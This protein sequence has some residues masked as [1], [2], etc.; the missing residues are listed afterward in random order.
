MPAPPI[1]VHPRLRPRPRRRG[2]HRSSPPPAR[3]STCAR[4]RPWP[5]TARSST[6]RATR[7]GCARW[8]ASA[9]CR[10]PRARAARCARELEVAADVHGESALD[11]PPLPEPD[12]DARPAPG[13]TSSWPPPSRAADEPVTLVA[14]GPLTN[15]AAPPRAPSRGCRA[16]ARDRRHGRLDRAAAT[17]PRTPSSTSGPTPRRPTPCSRSGLPVTLSASTSPTRR[18]PRREVV[19]RLERLGTDLA[20]TDGGVDDL[21][22]RLLPSASGASPRRRS[23][24]RARSPLAADPRSSAATHAFVAVETRGRV[25]ARRDGRR[26]PRPPRPRAQRPRRPRP[27]RRALLGPASS[28]PSTR[29]GAPAR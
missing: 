18:W 27:R 28:A 3:C 15:V 6:S 11:G 24:T 12:V 8:R 29:S 5:A 19:E 13:A 25:D 1:P 17:A 7:C 26:P 16:P 9:T 4:S 23:T 2:R 22:R 21:V 14:V 20:R 10:S